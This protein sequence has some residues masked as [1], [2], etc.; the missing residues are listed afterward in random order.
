MGLVSG[1][2]CSEY[3]FCQFPEVSRKQWLWK[4]GDKVWW[5]N[6]AIVV[7]PIPVAPEMPT[8][9]ISLVDC[10][11]NISY[12]TAMWRSMATR[13]YTRYGSHKLVGIRDYSTWR[14]FLCSW[15][16]VSRKKL[17]QETKF[18]QQTRHVTRNFA[19]QLR[20]ILPVKVNY[21]AE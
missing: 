16:V 21:H 9:L 15:L 11:S 17:F 14:S 8:I 7:L 2:D 13:S 19:N 18:R 3:L 6:L 12:I 4:A 5:M 1:K 10:N 20:V